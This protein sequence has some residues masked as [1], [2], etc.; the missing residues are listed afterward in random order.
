MIGDTVL[1]A[2]CDLSGDV[3]LE[4]FSTTEERVDED[5][6]FENNDCK[7]NFKI[8]TYRNVGTMRIIESEVESSEIVDLDECCIQFGMGID[9]LQG[10]CKTVI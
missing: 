10:A 1:E 3:P 6:V 7:Q 5:L 8:I 9:S 2:A 4:C